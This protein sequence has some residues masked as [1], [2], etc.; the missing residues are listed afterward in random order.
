LGKSQKKSQKKERVSPLFP[1]ELLK[2]SSRGG[3]ADFA[4]VFFVPAFLE[5]FSTSFTF[6]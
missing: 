2:T 6:E 3:Y 5:A 4:F 1:I